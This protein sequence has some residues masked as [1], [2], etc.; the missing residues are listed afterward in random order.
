MYML[1][2]PDYADPPTM[3]YNT[4]KDLDTLGIP[5]NVTVVHC[6]DKTVLKGLDKQVVFWRPW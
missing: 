2:N 6:M 5:Q 3:Y 1:L 4:E